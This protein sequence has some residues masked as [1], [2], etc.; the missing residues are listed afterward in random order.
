MKLARTS[1]PIVFQA[2]S[3]IICVDSFLKTSVE[4]MFP[5]MYVDV[6]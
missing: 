6:W 3:K 5:K 1:R 2:I 4:D